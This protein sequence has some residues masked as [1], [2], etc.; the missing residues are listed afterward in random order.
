MMRIQVKNSRRFSQ[1]TSIFPCLLFAGCLLPAFPVRAAAAPA[2]GPDVLVFSNGDKL[3]GKLDHEAGG[4]IYF[5]SDEA[6]KVEVPWAKLKA[7]HTGE[8]FAVIETGVPVG[9]KKANT[10]VPVGNISIEGDTLTVATPGGS[11]QIPVKSIAYLVDQS[12]FDK[13]VNKKQGFT[14][15][16]TGAITAGASTVNSTQNSVSIN[17]G[18]VLAR[19]V[20][21]VSWMP[22]RQRTLL[23]FNSN[24]G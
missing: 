21:P 4:T 6:D 12:T 11:R 17:S 2:A 9:R 1:M 15:G 13:N 7:L 24:Y 14:E 22:P 5:T 18:V 20:P 16:I 3:T 19:A 10:N 8:P 23:N